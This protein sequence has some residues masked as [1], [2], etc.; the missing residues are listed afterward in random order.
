DLHSAGDRPRQLGIS[1][2]AVGRE[3]LAPLAFL[4]L[5]DPLHGVLELHVVIL[6]G[7]VLGD[8]AAVRADQSIVERL[9][10]I[11]LDAKRQRGKHGARDGELAQVDLAAVHAPL[12]A[13]LLEGP[14]AR[15]A[16][17]G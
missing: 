10:W 3:P 7:G 8:F 5:A 16:T 1:R 15:C 13:A 11:A 6:R 12:P 14:I 17:A 2:A 4:P 9:A